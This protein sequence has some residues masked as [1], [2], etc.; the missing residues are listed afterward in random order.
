MA[1]P[2]KESDEDKV[3]K[4]ML[5]TPPKPHK[6]TRKKDGS[7]DGPKPRPKKEPEDDAS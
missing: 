1:D 3:L 4:R 7:K 5:D 2:S 6:P